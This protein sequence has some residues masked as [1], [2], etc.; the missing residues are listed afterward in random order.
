MTARNLI[1]S[2]LLIFGAGVYVGKAIDAGELATYREAHE[3]TWS[4]LRR[5]AGTVVLG[6]AAVGGLI[7]AARIALRGSR[8]TPVQY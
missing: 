6:T 8:S 5:K 3:S 2:H 7:L 4:K 1:I